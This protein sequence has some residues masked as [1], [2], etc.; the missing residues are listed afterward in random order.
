MVVFRE[1]GH[2]LRAARAG[3]A[4]QEE[5]GRIAAAH[6]DWP[7]FRVGVNSGAA[8]VGLPEARGARRLTVTGDT[9]NVAARLEG[10]ARAGEV[11][12]GETTRAA[13][14]AFAQVE[15]LGDL[16]VKGKARPVRAFLLRA[17]APE[18]DERDQRLQHEQAKSEP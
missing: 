10:Q 9:V 17:L 7:R 8:I 12:I 1:E 5:T 11:V 13:L 2:A 3:L 4:F 14:G 15:D 18:G 16:P 6:P